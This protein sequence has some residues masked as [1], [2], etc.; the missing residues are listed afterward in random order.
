M[1]IEV[2][3]TGTQLPEALAQCQDYDTI[4]VRQGVYSFTPLLP[5][6]ETWQAH[7]DGGAAMTLRGRKGVRII[8]DHGPLL[9]FTPGSGLCV[10]DCQDIDVSG[11]TFQGQGYTLTPEKWYFALMLLAGHNTGLRVHE[12]SFWDSGNHGI[13]HLMGGSTDDSVFERNVFLRG[14]H[15]NRPAD[16]EGQPALGGDGAALAVRG[17]RNVYRRNLI[18]DWLRGIEIEAKNNE[19]SNNI[20]ELN[21]LRNVF[22]H[23]IFITPTGGDPERCRRNI[24]RHNLL[25]SGPGMGNFTMAHP[26]YVSGGYSQFIEDNQIRCKIGDWCGIDV[27]ANHCDLTPGVY[28]NRI[29]GG[30]F[31]IGVGFNGT[32]A[33]KIG[34]LVAWNQLDSCEGAGIGYYGTHPDHWVWSNRIGAVIA[35]EGVQQPIYAPDDP[36]FACCWDNQT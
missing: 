1:H 35:R 6:T 15:L 23:G 11:L 32:P 36:T 29:F 30:R 5:T 25:T 28:R 21:E 17:S 24:I 4:V 8:G 12:C 13:G 10:M 26:I 22:W 9:K 16:V 33:G 14:G 7:P 27:S 18:V 19:A 34:A 2:T 31:G 20:A 3:P